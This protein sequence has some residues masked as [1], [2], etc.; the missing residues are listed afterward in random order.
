MDLWGEKAEIW[1]ML[2]D[3]GMYILHILF[4]SILNCS[5]IFHLFPAFPHELRKKKKTPGRPGLLPASSHGQRPWQWGL[6]C[7]GPRVKELNIQYLPAKRCPSS[8][9]RNLRHSIFSYRTFWKAPKSPGPSLGSQ[10]VLQCLL[11]RVASMP[12]EML[13]CQKYGCMIRDS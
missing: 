2:E 8:W 11:Y 13:S 1:Q 7:P 12:P 5:V 4:T 6:Q 9:R 3:P 10:G